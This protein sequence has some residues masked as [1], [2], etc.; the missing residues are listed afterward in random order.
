MENVG[1]F[2]AIRYILWPF[3]IFYEY[4]VYYMAIWYNMWPFGTFD[5]FFL[6]CTKIVI[7]ICRELQ[8]QRYKISQCITYICS[9]VRFLR[10]FYTLKNTFGKLLQ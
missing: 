9:L 7:K 4:L 2:L 3:D 10:F 8:R 6:L 5:R 1:I